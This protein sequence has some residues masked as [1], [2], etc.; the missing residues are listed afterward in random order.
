MRETLRLG[1]GAGF[2]GDRLDAPV[3]LAEHGK[4]DYLVL[5]C[6]A[7]RTI[8][9][10]QLRRRHDP[11]TGYDSRLEQRI[12]SLLPILVR[13]GIRLISN[14][15]AANPIAAADSIV[16]IARR[17]DIPVKVAA[18][19]GDDVLDLIDLDAPTMESGLPL[20]RYAPLVSA[21]AYLGAEAILPALASGADIVVTGR[22]ADPSLFVAPLMHEY[23]W[24][25]D[26]VDRLARGTAVGHL[27]ECAGQIT[28]GYFA[29]PGLKD[30]ADLSRLGFPIAEVRED[31]PVVVTKVAGSGG[32]VTAATCKEQLLYE[33]HD[34]AAY[35]TPDTVAD[36]SRVRVTE[37]GIDRVAVDGATGRPRPDLLKVS[38][39]YHDGYVGE[40]QVS[41]AGSG[42]VARAQLAARI[43]EE[44]LQRAGFARDSVRCDLVGLDAIHGSRLS[45][46][47]VE[48]YEVRLRV[49]A[50]AESLDA[51]RR[52]GHEVEAL[53]T[54]GPA[55]GAGAVTSVRAGVSMASTFIPREAVTCR[56]EWQVS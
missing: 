35:L 48:P 29:D 2:A 24:A 45:S 18:V 21:N 22:V 11:A 12:A 49:V 50:R 25:H 15:G 26:D 17:L 13:R 53:Y 46:S 40:G 19:T 42:A 3:H 34:P 20:S 55:G 14:F 54:N 43:V 52:V 39:G 56:V 4:L 10:A 9:L 27:L 32:R 44:R 23:G 31:D 36:F 38:V 51:A 16:A 33:I 1:G 37:L 47:G 28:G 41:Y 30:V 8:A 7:E 6:L 5:E